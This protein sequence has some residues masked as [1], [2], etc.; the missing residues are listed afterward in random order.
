VRR[1]GRR[2]NIRLG[3]LGEVGRL[4]L[5]R[6]FDLIVCSDVLHYVSTAEL[7]RGLRSLRRLAKGVLWLEVYATE[8]TFV[9][10]HEGWQNRS[11]RAYRRIFGEVGLVACGLNCWV[12]RRFER[13]LAALER[14]SR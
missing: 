6:A 13:R 9:G 4:Q 12:P 2:R 14:G 8:D 1:F 10:D 7:R 5:G 11:E 3:S